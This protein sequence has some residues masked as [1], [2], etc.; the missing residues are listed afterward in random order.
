MII[1]KCDICNKEVDMIYTIV[2]Y[3]APIDYCIECKNR[4]EEVTKEFE[5][6]VRFENVM[7]D[8]NLKN[9]E[10]KYLKQLKL[11]KK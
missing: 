8:T 9:K 2:L 5:K 10:K 7:M 11:T 3:K 6:D 4:V 1:R